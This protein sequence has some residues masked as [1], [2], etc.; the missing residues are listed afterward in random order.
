MKS[1]WHTLKNAM[2]GSLAH[3][4]KKVKKQLLPN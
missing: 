1:T 3:T 2:K 4:A